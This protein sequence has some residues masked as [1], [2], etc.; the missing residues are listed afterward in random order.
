M[1]FNLVPIGEQF[2]YQDVTYTKSGPISASAELDGKSRMIPRSAN[3]ML[4]NRLELEAESTSVLDVKQL[5]SLEVIK[6]LNYYHRQCL[7][8]LELTKSDISK[9]IFDDVKS[10]MNRAHQELMNSFSNM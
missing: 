10:K 7:E 8:Y 1:K 2:S 6:G 9:E 3:V 5:P 4:S